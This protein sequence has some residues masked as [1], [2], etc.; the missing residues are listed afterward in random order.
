MDVEQRRQRPPPTP[1]PYD[2]QAV[3][4]PAGRAVVCVARKS[5][6]AYGQVVAEILRQARQL[7][8]P[9]VEIVRLL[10]IGDTQ[11]NEWIVSW[12]GKAWKLPS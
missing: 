5:E 6:P 7:D 11:L 10:Y 8:R 1:R 4:A 12:I 9:G 3:L 2:V